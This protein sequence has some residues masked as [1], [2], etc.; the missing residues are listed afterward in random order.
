MISLVT[1]PA[2]MKLVCH[3]NIIE[4]FSFTGSVFL[5]Q[6]HII[7]ELFEL[8]GTCKDHLVQ[9]PYNELPCNEQCG[10]SIFDQI[11]ATVEA[12]CTPATGLKTLIGN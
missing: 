6:N 10:H 1:E 5:L 12:V 7:I 4:P 2:G 3:F 8:K 11:L 9:L